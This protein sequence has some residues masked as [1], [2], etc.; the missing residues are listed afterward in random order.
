MHSSIPAVAIPRRENCRAFAD[1][2]SLGGWV[3]AYPR[4]TFG[5]LRYTWERGWAQLELTYVL[6]YK[7]ATF[8]DFVVFI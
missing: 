7:C 3:L 2:V 8:I 5:L 1:I 4:V 6:E